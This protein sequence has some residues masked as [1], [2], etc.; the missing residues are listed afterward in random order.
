[1]KG[2]L[3]NAFNTRWISKEE[4]APVYFRCLLYLNNWYTS[5]ELVSYQ[6]QLYADSLENV[7][8]SN[9]NLGG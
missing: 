6:T 3:P 4:A 9:L 1:M 8:I 5:D 2:D 7:D